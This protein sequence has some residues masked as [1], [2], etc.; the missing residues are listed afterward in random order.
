MSFDPYGN[1]PDPTA[2]IDPPAPDA[3]ARPPADVARDR[4]QLPGIFLM[5]IGLLNLLYAGS[6]GITSYRLATVPAEEIEKVKQE[7]RRNPVQKKQLEELEAK[8][9]DIEKLIRSAGTWSAGGG[10]AAVLVSLLGIFGGIRMLQL[11]SYGLCVFAAI[12]SAIPCVSGAG[13]CCI[14]EAVGVWAIVVLLS[15]DVRSAFR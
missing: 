2:P 10:V 4:V 15:N 1:V 13:C 9:F 8:G 6:L 5:V 11:K 12:V 14:G 7:M 3:G